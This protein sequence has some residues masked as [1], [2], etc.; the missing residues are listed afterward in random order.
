MV[1]LTLTVAIGA[2]SAVFSA[3]RAVLLRPLPVVEP[4]RAVVLWQT[5][6]GAG[7]A[8]IEL[9]LRHL[10]EWT[11]DQSV[12][13]RAAVMGSHNWDVVFDD[14]SGKPERVH[15]NG[16]SSGFFE[17][18]GAAPLLGRTLR[19]EDDTPAAAPVLVLNHSSWVRRFAADP[20][21]VGKNM[22]LDGQ[23]VEIVGV[24][25]EGFDVPR[26]AEFWAPVMPVLAGGASSEATTV[27][28]VVNNVGVFYLVGRVRPGVSAGQI[29]RQVDALDARLQ[30]EVPGRAKWGD[31][32]VVVPL[33]EYVFGPVRPVLWALWA[34]VTVLLLIACANVSGLML[35]RATHRRREQAVRLA[36][37]ATRA[38]L[39]RAW[40]AEILVLSAVGGGLGLLAAMSIGKAIAALAPDDVTGVA[41]IS[42]DGLVVL[43]TLAA[44]AAVATLIGALPVR[45]LSRVSLVEAF[46]TGDRST[47]ARHSVRARSTL[48]VLQVGLSVALLVAA[49]LVVRS[50]MNLT[51]LDLGFQPANVLSLSIEP[52]SIQGPA[53]QWFE[54]LIGRVR[55]L[56]GVEAAGSVLLRP[57]QLGPI[58]WGARVWLEGQEQTDVVAAR[59]PAVN[60]QIATP[61]YF[62]AMRIPILHGRG[63]T[64][65]DRAGTDR[66]AIVS[67]AAARGLWP[68]QDPIGRRI[69]MSSFTPGQPGRVW[70]TVVGV[71]SNVRYRGLTEVQLDIYDTAL[72]ASRPAQSLAV[73]TTGSPIGLIPAIQSQVRAL[74]P[75]A[76]ID[77]VVTMDAVVGRAVAPWRLSMWMFLLFASVAFGLALTGLVSVVAL[78][79]AHRRQEFAIRLALGASAR[80]ILSAALGRTA[81]RV[82]A[83]VVLGALAAAVGTRALRSLLFDVAPSDLA[84]FVSVVVFVTITAAVAAYIPGRRAART[85]VS[86][87]LRHF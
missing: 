65:A 8:V 48:L 30:R 69:L 28:N 78:D 21:I 67:E 60:Y 73:R 72:Q 47:A 2:N 11:A 79:V 41:N 62:E 5:D 82:G 26:G 83:G 70:R 49:G 12:F 44:V 29:A 10:R 19:P 63:F 54:E 46:G 68:S 36:M 6:A 71:V 57:L 59:N 77:N 43:F 39:G 80:A 87:L 27:Q 33:V 81:W 42:V 24:M 45:H 14:S 25:P 16:V 13:Q 51:R 32:A 22:N 17:T 31:R 40:M 76:V 50:F 35:T 74:D 66:V 15:F 64:D 20:H 55:T 53:N 84:T 7:Q 61:G 34:A 37:G 4:E 23:S 52:R 58:G 86:T 38:S 3:V 75:T 1:V 85:E 18:L 56:P 9:T